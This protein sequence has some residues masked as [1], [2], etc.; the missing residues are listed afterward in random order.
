MLILLAI[1]LMSAGVVNHAWGADASVSAT[2]EDNMSVVGGT[3]YG[4]DV[5]LELGSV[6]EGTLDDDSSLTSTLNSLPTLSRGGD[7]LGS[8]T[9]MYGSAFA[10]DEPTGVVTAIQMTIDDLLVDFPDMTPG[11]LGSADT[12]IVINSNVPIGYSLY[13]AEDLPLHTG[14][15]E[16]RLKT[17]NLRQ[18]PRQLIEDTLGD[19]GTASYQNAAEWINPDVIGFGY[20]VTGSDALGDFAGGTRYKAFADLGSDQPA[21]V[22]AQELNT[23]QYLTNRQVDVHYQVGVKGDNEVGV[24][25]NHIY[26]TLVPNF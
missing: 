10:S 1:F 14:E 9:G 8:R 11:I 23:T 16:V 25:N 2:N 18:Y 12:Q 22:I 3:S 6:S 4:E 13:A 26:Y 15:T 21:Q 17:V 24:Y 5:I 7:V 20:T 19:D